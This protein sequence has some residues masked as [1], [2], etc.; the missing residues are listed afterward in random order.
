MAD[1]SKP[2]TTDSYANVLTYL[3]ATT[4][5]LALGLDPAT[6]TPTNVPTNA[7]RWTSAANKWQKWNGTA[8][9]DLSSLYA[10]NISGN[11]AT[12]TSATSATSATTATN[13]AGGV[14]GAI[15]YQSAA[16]ASAFSAAGTAGQ[17]LL[18]GGAAAPTWGTLG[19]GAGGT[20]ATTQIGA[21]QALGAIASQTLA[22][23]AAYTVVAADRGDVLLCT[24]TWSLSL[25]A[26][27]TLANGFSFGVVN[28]GTGVIT[29]DPNASETVDGVTTKA[30]APGQSCIL[31]TDGTE[32]RT[33]GLSGG[34]AKGGGSD[35][36]FYENAQNVAS[37]Y[38]ITS[39]KNAMS[40]GPITVNTGV[41][42]TIPTG[43]VWTI[44]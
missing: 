35:D 10:I 1:F 16:G 15:H 27:S 25:T 39:G 13:L 26:A 20:G 42:V 31:I 23:S 41:T 40:A 2:V 7:V 36:V 12:A 9:V 19:L 28:I 4:S 17:V 3:K 11:A 21:L 14:A 32:W 29:I 6:T 43:S 18:S 30:L 33:V 5:D 8:W 44:V 22:K 38:T 34:G 37:N 24:G